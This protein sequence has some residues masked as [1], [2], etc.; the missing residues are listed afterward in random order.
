MYGLALQRSSSTKIVSLFREAVHT[1]KI[2]VRTNKAI[3]KCP[4]T[5]CPLR[6]KDEEPTAGLTAPLFL[7]TSEKNCCRK[8]RFILSIQRSSFDSK[9]CATSPVFFLCPGRRLKILKGGEMHK[10]QQ[11]GLSF[12]SLSFSLSLSLTFPH[13]A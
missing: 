1:L 13:R 7:P 11:S 10:L 2:M 12:L 5:L 6:L 9:F 4:L 8:W 3:E